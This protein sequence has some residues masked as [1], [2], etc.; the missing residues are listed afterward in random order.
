MPNFNRS[1]HLS[2]ADLLQKLTSKRAA[3][4]RGNA[5]QLLESKTDRDLPEP[6]STAALMDKLSNKHS[7]KV[8]E[9]LKQKQSHVK[10][11]ALHRNSRLPK[12]ETYISPSKISPA[13]KKR[14]KATKKKKKKV[15]PALTEDQAARILQRAL[16]K[17]ISVAEEHLRN[18]VQYV[19]QAVILQ[20]YMRRFI[21]Q[22]R[23]A[24][25]KKNG[26][27]M[28]YEPKSWSKVK[29]LMVD[30]LNNQGQITR[31]Q[32]RNAALK[33]MTVRTKK[34]SLSRQA[35]SAKPQTPIRRPARR[36]SVVMLENDQDGNPGLE[37]VFNG[38]E[39]DVMYAGNFLICG[40]CA[41]VR[42]FV[43]GHR[44]PGSKDGRGNKEG[45][46]GSKEGSKGNKEGSRGNKEGSGHGYTRKGSVSQPRRGSSSA[47]PDDLKEV[48]QQQQLEHHKNFPPPQLV[49]VISYY[50]EREKNYAL[51]INE[52][53]WFR[54]GYGRWHTLSEKA[55]STLCRTV[56]EE[57]CNPET[58]STTRML[59]AACSACMLDDSEE[60]VLNKQYQEMDFDYSGS[61]DFREFLR[62][63]HMDEKYTHLVG[64]L[65]GMFNSRSE[66]A[67]EH[68]GRR[69]SDIDIAWA[70]KQQLQQVSFVCGL[71]LYCTSSY[72]EVAEIVFSSTFRSGVTGGVGS[73]E[74]EEI[75][76]GRRQSM[77]GHKH[78]MILTEEDVEHA[79]CIV[80]SCVHHTD[81]LHAASAG[82]R[83]LADVADL[84]DV[85]KNGITYPVDLATWKHHCRK[86]PT[87]LS[88]AFELQEKLR[89]KIMGFS[90][91]KS[92]R[93]R[94]VREVDRRSAKGGGS[95]VLGML[96]SVEQ[97]LHQEN[98]QSDGAVAN[99]MKDMDALTTKQR[100]EKA[101]GRAKKRQRA[102]LAAVQAVVVTTS[103]GGAFSSGRAR[104]THTP[105]DSSQSQRRHARIADNA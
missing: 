30:V 11:E 42:C 9:A 98:A 17:K 55:Q 86:S 63:Y 77:G 47:V 66:S 58:L 102:S 16:G 69:P 45:S 75:H 46:R 83:T 5:N 53:E 29:S 40:K 72:D 3:K 48:V 84:A 57:L 7:V 1:D 41:H 79:M 71:V 73:D 22:R 37:Q 12:A 65:F 51:I 60:S 61:I 80:H 54:T 103:D 43:V 13:K 82:G 31:L 36:Q 95:T 14:R 4:I 28:A 76:M 26:R 38:R 24:E 21:A 20:S 92:Y 88:P 35:S 15:A 89:D 33:R 49:M 52:K 23:A 85:L 99:L 101:R 74:E 100:A 81:P 50:T 96:R 39:R 105:S 8:E 56:A 34:A 97:K 90:W 87:L 32:K 25:L 68:R 62:Y 64:H 78:Q 27:A 59:R 93:E 10:P 19:R 104:S 91:W 67:A 6:P 44:Q 18:L 94:V 70:G 2:T